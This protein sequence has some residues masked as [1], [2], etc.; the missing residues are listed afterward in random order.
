MIARTSAAGLGLYS[1][2]QAARLIGVRP[3]KVRRWLG[4]D[5]PIVRHRPGLDERNITFLELMELH[6]V[7][8]FRA[9]GVSMPTIRKAAEAAARRFGT[10]YPFAVKR[11]DTDGHSIF[12]TLEST[13]GDKQILEELHR[14]QLVFEQI[15]RPFFRK[16][17]YSRRQE[18]E[19][20]RYWPLEPAGR[21]VLDPE[22]DF[23]QPIDA[24]TGV[25]TRALYDACTAGGGQDMPTVAEWFD[26]PLEAVRSAVEFE[27]SLG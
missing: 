21:V 18:R 7:K 6:F 9:E 20:I 2:P 26:V 14:G 11:F 1:I 16:L 25:P 12:A 17:E 4:E 27:Q 19:A 8:M 23:G 10:D 5:A 15:A 24:E 22:R 13:E 3:Q